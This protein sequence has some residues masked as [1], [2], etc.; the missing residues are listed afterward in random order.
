MASPLVPSE[1]PLSTH[2]PTS[3]GLK[4]ELAVGLWLVVPTTRFEPT[5]VDFTRFELKDSPANI[6]NLRRY[7]QLRLLK[8]SAFM[9]IMKTLRCF[10]GITAIYQ[11]FSLAKNALSQ[12]YM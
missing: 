5:Q 4:A 10:L 1:L 3:E 9:E 8:C 12:D 2:L 7:C 6:S 11:P